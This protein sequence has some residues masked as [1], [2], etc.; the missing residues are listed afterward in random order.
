MNNMGAW[1]TGLYDCDMAL[2][3]RTSIEEMFEDGIKAEDIIKNILEEYENLDE[4]EV[5]ILWFTLADTL[6]DF[7][8]LTKDILKE[9]KKY[10]SGKYD[11]ILWK[12]MGNKQDIKARIQVLKQ[13]KSKLY[14]TKKDIKI[15]KMFE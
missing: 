6:Y 9:T 8:S 3:I 2:D 1:A 12:E 15:K 7:N 5:S 11:L 13:L 10:I 14:R 4:E